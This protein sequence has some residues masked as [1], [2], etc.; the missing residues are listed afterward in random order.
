MSTVRL[1]VVGMNYWGP[2]L[3]RNFARMPNAEL[4]WCCDLDTDVLDRHRPS[5]PATRFT[6]RYDDLLEDDT[7]DAVV[8]ATS[9]PSTPRWPSARSWRASTPSSKSRSP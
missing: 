1:G 5:Y 8:I 7:L 4:A 2:N 9:V 6:T 3:A